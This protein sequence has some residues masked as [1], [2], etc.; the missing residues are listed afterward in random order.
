MIDRFWNKVQKG[1]KNSCWNW[2]GAKNP[3]GY[4]LLGIQYPE[5]RSHRFSWYLHNGKIPKKLFVLHSCDNPSCV[6]PNHLFLG[7]AQDNTNDMIKKGRDNFKVNIDG[8][9]GFKKGN[10]GYGYRRIKNA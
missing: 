6:N 2:L 8:K 3:K 9:F 4:G 5:R 10:P 7:T 1:N